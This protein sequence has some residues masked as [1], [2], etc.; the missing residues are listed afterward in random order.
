MIKRKFT[1]RKVGHALRKDRRSRRRRNI[2]AGPLTLAPP[3]R[4]LIKRAVA[5]KKVGVKLPVVREDIDRQPKVAEP[6]EPVKFP[7]PA[8]PPEPPVPT[9]YKSYD[10]VVRYSRWLANFGEYL[11]GYINGHLLQSNVDFKHADRGLVVGSSLYGERETNEFIKFAQK[12]DKCVVMFTGL[13]IFQ[14][15]DHIY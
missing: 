10:T 5:P 13:D 14:T 9:E 8:R 1:Y 11:G 6:P 4:L 2:T 15:R 7:K 12:V 3:A